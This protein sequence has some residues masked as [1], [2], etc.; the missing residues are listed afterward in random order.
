MADGHQPSENDV[1]LQHVMFVDI[2]TTGARTARRPL[3]AANSTKTGAVGRGRFEQCGYPIRSHV[4][5][6]GCLVCLGWVSVAEGGVNSVCNTG[7]ASLGRPAPG[8]GQAL[9]EL[10]HELIPHPRPMSGLPTRPEPPRPPQGVVGLLHVTSARNVSEGRPHLIS[11]RRAEIEPSSFE[12]DPMSVET[13]PD[14]PDIHHSPSSANLRPTWAG[15][16]PASTR[17]CWPDVAQKSTNL[18]RPGHRHVPCPRV[19]CRLRHPLRSPML[20]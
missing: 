20:R 5:R 8:L 17:R 10:Q 1:A 11:G 3:R 18:A 16:G 4:R 14:L 15:C 19:C 7:S 2:G 6:F 13:M 12:A 9:P